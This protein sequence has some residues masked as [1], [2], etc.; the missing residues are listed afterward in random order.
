MPGAP[1]TNSPSLLIIFSSV[2]LAQVRRG[3]E[4]KDVDALRARPDEGAGSHPRGH[5]EGT[6]RQKRARSTARPHAE[7]AQTGKLISR[8]IGGLEAVCFRAMIFP[9]TSKLRCFFSNVH[10]STSS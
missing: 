5:G 9:T 2:K 6:H 1:L 10:V 3:D 8:G 4:G 7:K